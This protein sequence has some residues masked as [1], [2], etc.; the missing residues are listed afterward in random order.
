VSQQAAVVAVTLETLLLTL[1]TME[2]LR[3]RLAALVEM[4]L[5]STALLHQLTLLAALKTESR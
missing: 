4:V 2:Q 1:Q 3:M 5:V